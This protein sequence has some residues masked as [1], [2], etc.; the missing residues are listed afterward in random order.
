M[1]SARLHAS[2]SSAVAMTVSSTPRFPAET[3]RENIIRQSRVRPIQENTE[4]WKDASSTLDLVN[5]K[6]KTIALRTRTLELFGKAE[7]CDTDLT[8]YMPAT[9]MQDA[10]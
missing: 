7:T 9:I 3:L 10:S 2:T 6:A 4:L 5:M 1:G 8:S